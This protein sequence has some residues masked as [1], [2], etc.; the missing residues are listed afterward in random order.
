MEDKKVLESLNRAVEPMVPDLC[1]KLLEA[2]IEKDTHTDGCT[3]QESVTYL[4]FYRTIALAAGLLLLFLAGN[5]WNQERFALVSIDVNPGIEL[6]V[7]GQEHV[8]SVRAV[9]ED[10]KK[11]LEQIDIEHMDVQQ[12]SDIIIQKLCQGAYLKKGEENVA[13]ISVH[14]GRYMEQEIET[15]LESQVKNSLEKAS[16]RCQMITQRVKK[17]HN[18]E[19]TAKQYQITLGK[20]G[21][22]ERILGQEGRRYTKGQLASMQVKEL[23]ELIQR[24]NLEQESDG[25][26]IISCGM[27]DTRQENLEPKPKEEP[28]EAQEPVEKQQDAKRHKKPAHMQQDG[29]V[30]QGVGKDSGNSAAPASAGSA[31]TVQ[32]GNGGSGNAV[33]TDPGPAPEEDPGEGEWEDPPGEGTSIQDDEEGVDEPIVPGEP[34]EGEQPADPG[35]PGQPPNPGQPSSPGQPADPTNPTQPTDPGNT[36]E[37]GEAGN[38]N[39]QGSTGGL[40][41][42][43]GP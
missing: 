22:I 4:L 8:I 24:D 15:R 32:E 34:G 9:N 6:Q 31:P 16:L 20:A 14:R 26:Q 40:D 21:L 38:V 18:E 3:K 33:G 27:E 10:A 7:D 11:L 13:L 2:S 28:K 43:E 36:E 1:E 42:P 30:N 5:A 41:Q 29:M 39:G 25:L 37:P 17:T 19:R 23:F 12:A 35:A